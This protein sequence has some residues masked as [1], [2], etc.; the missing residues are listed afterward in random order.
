MND[1]PCDP[2]TVDLGDL[3]RRAREQRGLTVQDVA[4]ITR[5]PRRHLVALEHGQLDQLP[6]GM[7]RRA[8]V[9]TYAE[10]VGLDTTVALAQLEE[11]LAAESSTAPATVA[12]AVPQ[13]GPYGWAQAVAISLV[14]MAA[15]GVT[16]WWWQHQQPEPTAVETEAALQAALAAQATVAEPAPANRES[17]GASDAIST[18]AVPSLP[19]AASNDGG[20]VAAVPPN[21]VTADEVTR[22]ETLELTVTS[23]PAGARVLVDGL[24]YGRTPITIRHLNPGERRVRVVLDGY[25]SAERSVRLNGSRASTLKLTLAP[26]E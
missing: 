18:A 9:R 16:Y 4:A 22:T 13:Y 3:L 12:P 6:N 21:V 2:E 20:G 15:G 5:I 10:T 14:L 26:V 7:Y 24:G 17:A 8:E 23:S 1:L 25:V 11:A 19:V